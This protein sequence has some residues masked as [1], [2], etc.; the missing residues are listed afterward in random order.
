MSHELPSADPPVWVRRRDGSLVPFEADAISQSLFAVTERLGQPDA[1]LARELTDGVLHFLAGENEAI[2][3]TEQIAEIVSKSVREL[4]HPV[5]ARAFEEQQ[6]ARTAGPEPAQGKDLSPALP[7]GE[8]KPPPAAIVVPLTPGTPLEEVLRECARQ[9]HL[10]SVFARDVASLHRD[11]LLLLEGLEAPGQLAACVLDLAALE[12]PQ[13]WARTVVVDSPEHLLARAGADSSVSRDRLV[14]QLGDGLRQTE[15]RAVVNLHC[16]QPPSAV[17]DLAGGPLFAGQRELP[18]AGLLKEQAGEWLD[19]L[20][21]LD[22][23]SGRLWIH[24]HLGERDFAAPPDAAMARVLGLALAGKPIV[25]V[26]DR[27]RRPV[28]LAEGVDRRH[29]AVLLAVGL[30]LPRLAV[31]TGSTENVERFLQ[32]LGSLARLALSAAG[33]KRAYLRRASDHPAAGTLSQ[34]FLLDRA[35]LLVTPI[36]LD[37]VV[38]TLTGRGLCSGG[39]ALDLGKQIVQRLRDVLRQDG[40]KLRLEACLDGPQVGEPPAPDAD[41]EQVAGITPWD[42]LAN[43]KS[44]WRVAG[45]L[46]GVAEQG[47]LLLHVPAGATAEELFEMLRTIWEQTDVGRVAV[48]SLRGLQLG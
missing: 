21:G 39:T 7:P 3:S 40:R 18:S 6:H 17:D 8:E 25:L 43:A 19:L 27:P 46:H 48:G 12:Q 36:G 16:A 31:Q 47:T 2:L 14:R 34:G 45:A 42:R 29:P 26:L 20:L 9:Y 5:L 11:G 33:Q 38:R 1:F 22:L 24:W 35:R 44:Q 32:K 28:L 10:Q 23:P 37:A 13:R 41:P 4:G 15:R 30:H